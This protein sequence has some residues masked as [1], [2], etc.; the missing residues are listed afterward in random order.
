MLNEDQYMDRTP[1]LIAKVRA[2]REAAQ[3][4]MDRF[5]CVADYEV[6]HVVGH[7][8]KAVPV[9]EGTNTPSPVKEWPKQST[10]R[11]VATQTS[12]DFAPAAVESGDPGER[13]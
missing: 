11:A 1:D 4:E 9:F 13:A 7:G 10:A 5:T 3:K 12:I 6:R 8:P 2:L